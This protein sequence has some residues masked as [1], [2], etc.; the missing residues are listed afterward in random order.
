[1]Y[2][3]R[4]WGVLDVV[5]IKGDVDGVEPRLGGEVSHCLV[6]KGGPCV[7]GGGGKHTGMSLTV[8]R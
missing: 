7:W 6:S 5:I 1:M 3:G 8:L 4:E 2:G